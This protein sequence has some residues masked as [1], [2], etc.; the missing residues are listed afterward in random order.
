MSPE[1]VEGKKYSNKSDI[2]ALGCGN[3][4]ISSKIY[5]YLLF[6]CFLIN[7]ILIKKSYTKY[8]H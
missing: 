6:S 3:N 1:I 8:A 7:N 2:W 4:N 5:L